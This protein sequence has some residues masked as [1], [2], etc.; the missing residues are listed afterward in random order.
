MSTCKT[1]ITVGAASAP[2]I[3]MKRQAWHIRLVPRTVGV[4]SGRFA[5]VAGQ[6][7]GPLAERPAEVRRVVEA[8]QQGNLVQR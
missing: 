5:V 4:G 6:L 7:A 3:S 8:E 1:P 2:W